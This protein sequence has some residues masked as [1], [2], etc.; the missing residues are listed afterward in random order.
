MRKSMWRRLPRPPKVEKKNDFLKSREIAK[1]ASRDVSRILNILEKWFLICPD[2]FWV[3]FQKFVP[4]WCQNRSKFGLGWAFPVV[5]EKN[6]WKKRIPHILKPL[7]LFDFCFWNPFRPW[8]N[9]FEDEKKLSQE[10]PLILPEGT[11]GG[12]MEESAS[13]HSKRLV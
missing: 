4:K 10:D 11:P 9:W 2:R 7:I 8:E 1:G 12:K 5:P 6:R 3:I 13:H